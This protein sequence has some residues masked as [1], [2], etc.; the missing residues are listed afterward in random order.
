ME[1]QAGRMRLRVTRRVGQLPGREAASPSLSGLK[2]NY[3]LDVVQT[4]I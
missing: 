3:R 1:G 4:Y 2:K